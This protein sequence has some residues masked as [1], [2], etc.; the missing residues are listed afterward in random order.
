MP[1]EI[2]HWTLAVKA[3]RELQGKLAAAVRR[4]INIYYAGAVIPDTPSYAIFGKNA[5]MFAKT[6]SKIHGCSGENTFEPIQEYFKAVGPSPS[7]A[8]IAFALGVLAHFAADIAFHPFIYHFSGDYY[9]PNPAEGKEAR[10][11]HR[12]M[13]TI[14]DEHYM[15][16]MKLENG[17]WLTSTYREI[18]TSRDNFGELASLML[19]GEREKGR[20][21]IKAFKAHTFFQTLFRIP[22]VKLVTKAAGVIGKDVGEY[23]PLFYGTGLAEEAR[24]LAKP[25]AYKNHVTGENK[26]DSLRSLE[27]KA[28][29][30]T[31]EFFILVQESIGYGSTYETFKA[32]QGASLETGL[33]G[34]KPQEPLHFD[35]SRDIPSIL[36]S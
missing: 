10:R 5:D 26:S 36:F 9:S 13:E 7:E 34:V 35:T 27:E 25:V 3:T 22:E 15:K 29:I 17:G 19:F 11:R 20:E 31:S 28:L 18:E 4:N 32:R 30:L 21:C 2:T 33:I 24:P 16:E 8:E 6:A 12:M 1:K 23:L 14:I